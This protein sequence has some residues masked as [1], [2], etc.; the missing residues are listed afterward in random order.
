MQEAKFLTYLNTF[1]ID[2]ESE[3]FQQT[4]IAPYNDLNLQSPN[5]PDKH[6]EQYKPMCAGGSLLLRA[7]S[8]PVT[9]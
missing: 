5:K 4:S 3:N 2:L 6:I 1:Y 7:K 8:D 9:L